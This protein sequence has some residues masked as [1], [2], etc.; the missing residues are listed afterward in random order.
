[1]EEKENRRKNTRAA[2]WDNVVASVEIDEPYKQKGKGKVTIKAPV[3]DIGSKGMFVVSEESVPMNAKAEIS[4]DFDSRRPGTL[5]ISAQ[6][7]TVRRSDDGF[8]IQFKKIN[9]KHLMECIT[10][11]MNRS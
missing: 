1:M 2:V 7:K 4:I 3:R 10:G 9:L 11:R 8:G 5:T 6:G